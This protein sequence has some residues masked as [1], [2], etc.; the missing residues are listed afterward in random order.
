V[1]FLVRADGVLV[2][3]QAIPDTEWPYEQEVIVDHGYSVYHCS[4]MIDLVE[5]VR[6]VVNNVLKVV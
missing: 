3:V 1:N 5:Q 2:D 4:D 6:K